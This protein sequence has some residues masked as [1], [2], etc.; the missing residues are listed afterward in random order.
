MA[1]LRLQIHVQPRPPSPSHPFPTEKPVRWLEIVVGDPS[2]QDLCE[3]LERRFFERNNAVLDIKILTFLDG[4]EIYPSY[5]VRD[6]FEDIKDARDAE[7]SFSTV[8]VHRNAPSPS[9]SHARLE[10]LPPRSLARPRKRPLPP[11]PLFAE[12][13]SQTSRWPSPSA[14]PERTVKRPKI[15]DFGHEQA[16]A[17]PDPDH[18]LDSL[19]TREDRQSPDADMHGPLEHGK[20]AEYRQIPPHTQVEDSQRSPKRKS[21][22]LPARPEDHAKIYEK[23]PTPMG[24]PEIPSGGRSRLSEEHA[25][26]VDPHVPAPKDG[27]VQSRLGAPEAE[28]AGRGSRNTNRVVSESPPP[29][30]NQN[31]TSAPRSLEMPTLTDTQHTPMA[32]GKLQRPKSIHRPPAKK[33][34]LRVINGVPQ[35]Q[36]S[37]FDPDPID[38][39]EGS[40]HERELLKRTKRLKST[41]TPQSVAQG[42]DGSRKQSTK[43][44]VRARS[45]LS[46]PIG[47]PK[48]VGST[49]TPMARP[50]H[51]PDVTQKANGTEAE[52]Q[53]ETG[54]LSQLVH[55]ANHDTTSSEESQ[56]GVDPTKSLPYTNGDVQSAKKP[57]S[58][59]Q[60]DQPVFTRQQVEQDDGRHTSAGGKE[61]S[62]I[63]PSEGPPILHTVIGPDEHHL[64]QSQ[65]QLES[66]REAQATFDRIAAMSAAKKERKDRLLRELE[67][68]TTLASTELPVNAPSKENTVERSD[69]RSDASDEDIPPTPPGDAVEE[70]RAWSLKYMAPIRNKFL[71]PPKDRDKP[72]KSVSGRKKVKEAQP[73]SR[74]RQIGKRSD[75]AKG[76]PLLEEAKPQEQTVE[77]AQRLEGRDL[78]QRKEDQARIAREF[79]CEQR[80]Q[81][82]EAEKK[83]STLYE[84]EESL[85]RMQASEDKKLQNKATIKKSSRVS[86]AQ[87]SRDQTTVR[88]NEQTPQGEATVEKT[89]QLARAPS[90]SDQPTTSSKGPVSQEEPTVDATTMTPS[91]QTPNTESNPAER[92][93]KAKLNAARQVEIGNEYM[94]QERLKAANADSHKVTPSSGV[95]NSKVDSGKRRH[96]DKQRLEKAA[97]TK[98]R[99]ESNSESRSKASKGKYTDSDALRAAG[100][101]N[102]ARSSSVASPS[103]SKPSPTIDLT[104][105]DR[106]GLPKSMTPAMPSTRH[107]SVQQDKSKTPKGILKQTPSSLQRSVS[108]AA[109]EPSSS[110]QFETMVNKTNEAKSPTP[111]SRRRGSSEQALKNLD[112]NHQTKLD[113]HISPAGALGKGKGKEKAVEEVD[114][115][116]ASESSEASTFFSDES[117]NTRNSRAGPSSRKRK[118]SRSTPMNDSLQT[119]DP[120][121]RTSKSRSPAVYGSKASSQA[122]A[123][124]LSSSTRA[125]PSETVSSTSESEDDSEGES[126][127]ESESDSDS[128]SE[129]VSESE[130]HDSLSLLPRTREENKKDS[131]S[132]QRNSQESFSPSQ[133]LLQELDADRAAYSRGLQPSTTRTPAPTKQGNEKGRS[134][135]KPSGPSMSSVNGGFQKSSLSNLRRLQEKAPEPVQYKSNSAQNHSGPAL[136]ISSQDNISSSESESDNESSSSG[137]SVDVAKSQAKH[138]AKF[139]NPVPL[140][141]KKGWR[142]VCAELFGSG[143]K[144]KKV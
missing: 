49:E 90:S 18:P 142:K 42:S 20:T 31:S 133:Q 35:S 1:P 66:K 47:N 111:A 119:T 84:A 51:V 122:P 46:I 9:S 108:F 14:Q 74:F 107:V 115:S 58:T 45:K 29:E 10:S 3:I 8:Y 25:T 76:K 53:S 86:R 19:E 103:V 16:T 11:P 98:E 23:D 22:W 78:L 109:D 37:R 134:G 102:S 138:N 144:S 24:S 13:P 52:T 12:D 64:Q 57:A 96:S 132:A 105:S 87:G 110:F 44:P 114:S 4:I 92:S 69:S 91:A 70:Y 97:S 125:K 27:H 139:A 127:S 28:T 101:L 36:P 38:T 73:A 7:R 117:E 50:V 54:A 126:G 123:R 41:A 59:K 141:E 71:Q 94:R 67:A 104:K 17:D 112:K 43:S 118:K 68:K 75:E 131:K 128:E 6:I 129:S 56:T 120:E 143:G 63:K 80:K 21:K 5:K 55:A 130:S 77:E 82:K 99:G 100:L 39:S 113:R 60:D 26:Q 93:P 106:S 34:G 30:S 65:E 81:A 48:G 140:N 89:G 88:S 33:R 95:T 2:I 121:I 137:S 72:E 62:P 136:E 32:A 116:S 124:T 61:I 40:S 83:I 15:H 85:R 79:R 135:A